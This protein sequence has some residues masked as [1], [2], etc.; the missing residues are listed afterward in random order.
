MNQPAQAQALGNIVFNVQEEIH[1]VKSLIENL[2]PFPKG[3]RPPS[4]L[5]KL[6]NQLERYEVQLKQKAEEILT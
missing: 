1:K 4:P 5:A 6:S 3:Q 2:P